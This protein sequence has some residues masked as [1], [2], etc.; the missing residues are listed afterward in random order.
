MDTIVAQASAPGRAGVAVIRISGPA[1]LTAL[2]ALAG[3]VPEARR[4]TLMRLQGSAGVL[5]TAL[6]L[7]FNEGESFTGETV[8]ELQSHGSVAVTRAII[9]ELVA[10]EGLRLAEAGEFTRRALEND[11]LDLAQV[12]GLADLIE[13]ET[14]AQRLLAQATFSGAL[15]AKVEAWR[16]RLIRAA[17][18]LEAMIDFADEEVPEDTTADVLALVDALTTEFDAEALGVGAAERIREGFEVAIVGPPNAGKSTLL[19]RLAGRDAAIT[20]EVAGTTRDVIEVRMD[21]G[22]LPVTLLDT[23]GLRE[24]LDTVESIGVERARSR[25]VAA[26]LRVILGEAPGVDLKAGDISAHPKADVGDVPGDIL[27]L[28]G[29]TGQGIEELLTRI[30]A[31]LSSRLP[32]QITATHARHRVALEEASAALRAARIEVEAGPERAELAAEELRTALRRIEALT[33]RIGV[34]DLLGE[35][36]SSFCIGK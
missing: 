28:S 17:A 25:A 30:E 6:V 9:A 18:L 24:T 12:E 16:S 27:G 20:S 35:I 19:N 4:A 36:F 33:G 29:L 3:R 23:A 13:A 2:K 8:V 15:G 7:V 32:A 5:D 10:M 21:I 26:D 22:G 34:E 14:E 11:R 1:A 31:E